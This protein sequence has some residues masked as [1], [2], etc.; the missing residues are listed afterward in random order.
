VPEAEA[1]AA[2]VIFR[3]VTF[4]IPAVEGFFTMRSLEKGGY[5]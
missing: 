5:L 1:F 4:Y 3:M 2:T